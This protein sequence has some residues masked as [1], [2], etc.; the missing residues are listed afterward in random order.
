M[1]V[2][3]SFGF[4]L[5]A[6]SWLSQESSLSQIK[7]KNL[8]DRK[9]VFADP[10]ESS[11]LKVENLAFVFLVISGYGSWRLWRRKKMKENSYEFN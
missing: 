4:G 1:W 6:I 8:V 5:E 2:L 7:V 11:W 3:E 10:S 9:F